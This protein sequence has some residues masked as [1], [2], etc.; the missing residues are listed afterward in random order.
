MRHGSVLLFSLSMGLLGWMYHSAHHQPPPFLASLIKYF[1]GAG[2]CGS[3]TSSL[4]QSEPTSQQGRE[5]WFARVLCNPR[6]RSCPHSS[7]CLHYALKAMASGG[8]KGFLGSLALKLL[9][10]GTR[11]PASLPRLVLSPT[12]LLKLLLNPDHLRLALFVAWFSGAF[13]FGACACRRLRNGES[14]TN[15]A[16]AGSL[17]ALGMWFN[18]SPSLALYSAWKTLEVLC[19]MGVK[20]GHLPAVPYATELLYSIMTGYLFHVA[21]VHQQYIKPSYWRLLLNL[22]D[23]RM[24][25]FNRHLLYPYKMDSARNFNGFWPDYK[26]EDLSPAFLHAYPDGLV[27]IPQ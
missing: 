2:E 5:T 7:S 16:V 1:V 26:L 19:C 24:A 9:S 12:F 4:T 17:A 21:A 3:Q 22:T 8:V 13:R 25:Q 27:S 11:S 14:P 10:I 20:S 18:P 15:G 23:G 6:H